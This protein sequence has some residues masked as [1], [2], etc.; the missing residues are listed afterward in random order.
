MYL[1]PRTGVKN[2]SAWI[3]ISDKEDISVVAVSKRDYAE[4]ILGHE[5]SHHF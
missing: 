1:Q 4:S 2:Y 3:G 5:K